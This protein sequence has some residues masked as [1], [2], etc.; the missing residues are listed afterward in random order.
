MVF[1]WL[2]LSIVSIL[3]YDAF[4]AAVVNLIHIPVNVGGMGLVNLATSVFFWFRIIR[5]KEIQ[6]Y[7]RVSVFDFIFA[8]LFVAVILWGANVRWGLTALEW[9]YGAVDPSRHLRDALE[10]V[11]NENVSR[12]FLGAFING[13]FIELFSPWT[14]YVYYYKLYIITDVL[15][16]L[17]IGFMF[18]GVVCRYAKDVFVKVVAVI[19]TFF[20][21]LG[22]PVNSTYCGFT[23]LGMSLYVLAALLVFTDFFLKDEMEE[24]WLNIFLLMIG[25]H[26]IFQ[27]Y[28]L[29]MP[30]TF[31]AI[32]F[33]FLVKQYQ[34]ERLISLQTIREGLEIFLLP[35]VLGLIYT[36]KDI[37]IGED[38]TV[39]EAFLAEGGI[40]KDLYSNFLFFMPLAIW[41]LI[42]LIKKEGNTFL[43]WFAPIFFTQTIAMLIAGCY[44]GMVSSY[45]YYKNYFVLWM[46]VFVLL[47]YGCS[48]M[49]PQTRKMALLYFGS[50]AF[51]AI[52]F[53]T[54][55][56]SRMQERNFL[57]DINNKSQTYNDL[58][59]ANR[60]GLGSAAHAKSPTSS[61]QLAQYVYDE[62]LLSGKTEMP[63]PIVNHMEATLFYECITNQRLTDFEWW[64]DDDSMEE[65]FQNALECDY[66]CVMYGNGIY[67]EHM[68]FW[69]QFE[70]VYSNDA[71]KIIKIDKEKTV[72]GW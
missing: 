40:Y 26:A 13:T 22:Y 10:F 45:Y 16:L 49:S 68:P 34:R 15:Q 55:W 30:T 57:F 39:G 31:L 9:N 52:L 17:L 56:E 69:D 62:L 4:M 41:G 64:K 1:T 51:V 23:Y 27:C 46:L 67:E 8:G 70:V 38:I 48:E 21:V 66:V 14:K 58:L 37:F 61:E 60:D 72:Y 71:G 33:A 44:Y 3:F 63:V 5:K 32:G 11:K 28:V 53:I 25:A 19:A 42:K 12:M 36:Y 59:C 24:K 20:F 6:I 54:K 50:W 43:S 29:F 35:V 18:Y 47:V 65:F 2:P 7:Q